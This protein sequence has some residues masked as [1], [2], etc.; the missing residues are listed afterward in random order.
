MI[1]LFSQGGPPQYHSKRNQAQILAEML[2]NI[3][4]RGLH[5]IEKEIEFEGNSKIIAHDSEG[6]EAGKQNE[7]EVV[8]KFIDKRSKEKDINQRL[9]LVWLVILP[10]LVTFSH[11]SIPHRYCMEMN[12]R[13]IQQAEK[14]FFSTPLQGIFL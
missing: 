3:A 14:D 9:H 4:Q 7:V 11:G 13:P 5:D 12:S 8:R 2:N 6:F 1:F 10:L